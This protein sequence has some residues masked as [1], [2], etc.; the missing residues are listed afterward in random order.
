MELATGTPSV[1]PELSTRLQSHTKDLLPAVQTLLQSPKILP[2]QALGALSVISEVV[3][4]LLCHLEDPAGLEK[5]GRV[6]LAALNKKLGQASDLAVPV[7]CLSGFAADGE[8]HLTWQGTED[9]LVAALAL[10]CSVVEI[11]QLF[12]DGGGRALGGTLA[13]FPTVAATVQLKHGSSL[14]PRSAAASVGSIGSP[15]LQAPWLDQHVPR[16]GAA[17]RDF[18]WVVDAPGARGKALVRALRQDLWAVREAAGCPRL[19]SAPLLEELAQLMAGFE[20]VRRGADS[21]PTVDKIGKRPTV[22]APPLEL[23]QE[24]VVPV[25]V[26]TGESQERGWFE[27][28]AKAAEAAAAVDARAEL[29][30]VLRCIPAFRLGLPFAL[31]QERVHLREF[32]S[33]FTAGVQ[34]KQ[35]E[36]SVAAIVGLVSSSWSAST[37]I[38]REGRSAIGMGCQIDRNLDD[39]AVVWAIIA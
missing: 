4:R 10:Q 5:F 1:G 12:Q 21:R 18:P 23:A 30:I 6:K 11:Q 14:L 22:E 25:E 20:L 36:T 15:L 28:T 16:L 19:R 27:T 34:E 33:F 26:F 9:A 17:I 3:D 13:V 2:Q 35:F 31:L 37:E 7:L 29:V 38:S 24:A 32:P 39:T 8:E